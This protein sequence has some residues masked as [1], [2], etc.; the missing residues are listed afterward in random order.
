MIKIINAIIDFQ[1]YSSMNIISLDIVSYYSFINELNTTY[2]TKL[3]EISEYKGFIIKPI[4]C[5]DFKI[6]VY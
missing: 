1:C 6:E 3:K 4:F 5:S 2:G